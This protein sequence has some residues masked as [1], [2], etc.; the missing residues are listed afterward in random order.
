MLVFNCNDYIYTGEGCVQTEV[1]CMCRCSS[2]GDDEEGDGEGLG[3]ER[4]QEGAQA[5]GQLG[6]HV[7][8]HLP[9]RAVADERTARSRRADPET[10]QSHTT[11]I[12]QPTCS[13]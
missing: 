11:H 13:L 1:Q 4:Q 6:D 5:R 8:H 9:R 2:P 12:P 7:R 10:H 3:G